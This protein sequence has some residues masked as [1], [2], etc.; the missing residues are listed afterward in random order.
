M[1]HTV[2][3]ALNH[4]INPQSFI[5]IHDIEIIKVLN[6]AGI[7]VSIKRLD[8]NID[9]SRFLETTYWKLGVFMDL[10]CPFA[11]SD[12]ANIFYEASAHYMFDHLHNWLI[13]E[14]NGRNVTETMQ[15]LNDSTFSIITDFV[16]SISKDDECILYDVYN[17]CKHCGGSLNVVELGTWTR[18]NGLNVDLLEDKF[19]RRWNYNKLKVKAAGIVTARPKDQDLLEYLQQQDTALVDNWSKFGYSMLIEIA[20]MFNLTL[21]MIEL[22]HWE[23]DDRNGPLMAGLKQRD[24][25]VGYFPSIL[26]NDRLNY[27]NVALQVWPARTCFMFRTVPSLITDMNLI[28]RPFETTVWYMVCLLSIVIISTL[29]LI[30]K[31]HKQSDYG[32]STLILIAALCQQGLPFQNNQYAGRIAFLHTMIFG[33]LLYNCYS[34]AMVSSRL[35]VP[36][37]KMN[38]SLYS[39]VKSKIKLVAHKEVFF[40]VL[41]NSP[42]PDVQYFR[43]HWEAI[44]EEKRFEDLD[45]GVRRI[46]KPGFAYLADPIVI[47][48]LIERIFTKQ[49]ICQLTEVHLLRP[50]SLGMWTARHGQFHEIT[51]IGLIRITTSGIRHRQVKRWYSRKPYC[52][53]DKHYVSSVTIRETIPFILLLLVGILLSIIICLIENMVFRASKTDKPINMI[54]KYLKNIYNADKVIPII[55]A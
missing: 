52:D 41:I 50:S 26:T 17:H 51:K 34:A 48:P 21:D 32:E 25:D 45:E 18:I 14:E 27:A 46:L 11:D 7:L 6:D 24:F 10:R 4:S 53:M 38:D 12:A 49:M 31:V 2:I 15:S 35:N 20:A 43:R 39:L 33:L 19:T 54:P 9:V 23:K 5:E 40:N 28:F 44:P 3:L 55:V 36:L 13:L 42:A 1:K 37:N 8:S 22:T 16:I 29:W 30:W 47:Y